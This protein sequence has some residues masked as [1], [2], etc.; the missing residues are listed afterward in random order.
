MSAAVAVNRAVDVR[1]G[2]QQF[3]DLADVA[4]FRRLVDRA[5][6][7]ADTALRCAG[8]PLLLGWL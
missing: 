2:A 3:V 4:V 1:A 8:T 5:V 7:A 6:E